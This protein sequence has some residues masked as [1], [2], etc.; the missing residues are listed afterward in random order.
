[1]GKKIGGVKMATWIAHL[2]VAEKILKNSK[3]LEVGPF[4]VGN[5]GPDCGAPNEDWSKFSPPKS[6]SHW[7]DD[8][9]KINEVNFYYK[10]L[11]NSENYKGNRQYSFF[12]GY[13]VHLIT[14][15]E[16]GKLYSI[17]KK[18][19]LYC[20]GLNKNEKFIWKIK[21]DWYG[22]DFLYLKK[23]P[24]GIFYSDFQHIKAF[25]DYLD[26][27][28]QGAFTRQLNYIINYYLKGDDEVTVS[29]FKF[30][31]EKEMDEFVEN[32]TKICLENL[33]NRKLI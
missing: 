13:Y 7:H 4:L 9:G 20:E 32:T 33:S 19:P 18:E 6:V 30:L 23:N 14:D 26:Y 24:E 16:W 17:K 27:Y 10:H 2:R 12:V 3:N 28:P 8:T 1:M 21:E 25:E 22:Q 15:I 29:D 31:T 5:I 11:K